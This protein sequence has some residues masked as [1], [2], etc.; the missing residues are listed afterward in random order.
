MCFL[1]PACHCV[2]TGLDLMYRDN[3]IEEQGPVAGRE[4]GREG[5]GRGRGG[6]R[7]GRGGRGRGRGPPRA[8]QDQQEFPS[9]NNGSAANEGS[10]GTQVD[11]YIPH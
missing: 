10:S 2:R 6:R 9:E 5:G 1:D 4:G 8:Q 7:G 3:G 11:Y